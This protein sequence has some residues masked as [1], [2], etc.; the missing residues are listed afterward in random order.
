MGWLG[1][2][3][4]SASFWRV[5]W[6]LGLFSGPGGDSGTFLVRTPLQSEAVM[7]H[8]GAVGINWLMFIKHFD[9][10]ECYLT[11]RSLAHHDLHH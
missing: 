1:R 3:I 10:E 5:R 4:H 2:K 6:G 8:V 9:E 11:A 7:S